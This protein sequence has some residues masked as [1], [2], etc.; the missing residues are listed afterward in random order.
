MGM[1][2][3]IF[4]W[5][6]RKKRASYGLLLSIKYCSFDR[7]DVFWQNIGMRVLGVYEK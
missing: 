1:R 6:I 3:A 4:L 7:I 5:R 2:A